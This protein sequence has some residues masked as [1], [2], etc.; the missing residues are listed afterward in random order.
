MLDD[1]RSIWAKPVQEWEG[2]TESLTHFSA[3]CK[4]ANLFES[5]VDSLASFLQKYR[6]HQDRFTIK[7]FHDLDDSIEFSNTTPEVILEERF[8]D[9]RDEIEKLEG[10]EVLSFS[11]SIFKSTA[12]PKP[13]LLVDQVYSIDSLSA[14]LKG[15]SLEQVHG[16]IVTRYGRKDARG[17]ALL[18]D[19]ESLSHSEF[20][21]FVPKSQFSVN[22]FNPKFNKTDADES[23]R[24][25]GTLGHFSNASEWPFLPGHF[26]LLVSEPKELK[27]I[28]SVF[29]GL[30]NA[31]LIS[32]FA[33]LTSI[34]SKSIEYQL[35][36]LKDISG[37]YDFAA[38][39]N[40]DARYLWSLYK[41]VYEGS[42]V[43]KLGVTRNIIPLHVDDLLSVNEPVLA[44]AYSSFILSQKDDVKSYID[45]T[46][47]LADQMQV[48]AQK[49]GEAAEKVANSIKTGVFGVATFAISTILFRIFSKSSESYSYSDLFAFIGSDVFVLVIG[50]A[51][52]VFTSLFGFALV[53]SFQDQKRFGDMY[54]QSKK[55][56]ENVLTVEDMKNILNNDKYFKQNNRFISKRRN[57]YILVWLFVLLAVSITL[58]LASFY[59][60][61]LAG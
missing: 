44:S 6:K 7:V 47:K 5:D 33:N 48:T 11:L 53:E 3:S 4:L 58:M 28:A 59:A 23:K 43:D 20:F 30:L 1:V 22:S 46:S 60:Q 38:L 18:G 14:Y 13:G 56:Y 8:G 25:R 27:A 10:E 54:E 17:V 50:L 9:L 36:G 55:A 42:S 51:L 49:A 61:S 41:W 52:F 34:N 40:T 24:I 39:V 57:L 16:E 26:K 21:Y 19:F 37:S 31:Y 35:K 2:I 45:A 32:F 12:E 15:K 29:N